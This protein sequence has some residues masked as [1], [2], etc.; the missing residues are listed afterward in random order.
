MEVY[1]VA[2][3]N[4]TFSIEGGLLNDSF[5]G[6]INESIAKVPSQKQLEHFLSEV[7]RSSEF[8]IDKVVDTMSIK[9]DNQ[10][11]KCDILDNKGFYVSEF[12]LIF[13]R[14]EAGEREDCYL[15]M[16]KLLTQYE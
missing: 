11:K 13:S 4:D 16:V 10:P 5:S 9:K 12:E 6:Q 15:A 1:N 8:D 3:G 2:I 7:E 14:M